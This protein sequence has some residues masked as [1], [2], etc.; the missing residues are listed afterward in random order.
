MAFDWNLYISLGRNLCATNDE[1]NIRAGLSRAY[2]GLYNKLRIYKALTTKWRPHKDLIDKLLLAENFDEEEDLSKLLS[3][4]KVIREE[5][6]YN[7]FVKIDARYSERFWL[8]LDAA[9]E[10]FDNNTGH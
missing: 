9:L 2:Y 8:K 1:E 7:G 5:V 4:L 10:I 3:D 6:D